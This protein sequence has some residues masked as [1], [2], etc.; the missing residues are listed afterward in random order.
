MKVEITKIMNSTEI[1]KEI[2]NQLE[3][4]EHKGYDK[5]SFKSGY[6]LG[7]AKA[8]QLQQPDVI[9]SVC[10]SLPISKVVFFELKKGKYLASNGVEVTTEFILKNEHAIFHDNGYVIVERQ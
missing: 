7:Y 9:K 8:L 2:K 5:N 6:L 10:G 3:Q 1:L 4:L